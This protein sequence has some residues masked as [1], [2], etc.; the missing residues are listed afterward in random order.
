MHGPSRRKKQRSTSC[1]G[2]SSA[3]SVDFW[4]MTHSSSKGTASK[5]APLSAAAR[6]SKFLADGPLRPLPGRFDRAVVDQLPDLLGVQAVAAPE[7]ARG[8]APLP[9]SPPPRR[10][11]AESQASAGSDGSANVRGGAGGRGSSSSS[12]SASSGAGAGAATGDPSFVRAGSRVPPGLRRLDLAVDAE[13]LPALL[14]NSPER[15]ADAGRAVNPMAARVVTSI[16]AAFALRTVG[17][18][19]RSS[20]PSI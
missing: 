20:V 4:Q 2:V 19:R 10:R 7:R 6:A 3:S 11:R 14:R 13:H 5:G 12:S 16:S 18:V 1:I 15:L 17:H 9:L 8:V